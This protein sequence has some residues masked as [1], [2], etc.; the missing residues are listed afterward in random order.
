MFSRIPMQSLCFFIIKTSHCS[1]SLEAVQTCPLW[2]L[3]CDHGSLWIQTVLEQSSP[4]RIFQQERPQT[5]TSAALQN[6]RK[7]LKLPE[8]DG[9]GLPKLTPTLEEESVAFRR[10][11]ED[12][13]TR[14][15]KAIRELKPAPINIDPTKNFWTI[16]NQVADEHDNNL[17]KKYSGDLDTSLLFAT[18]FF[19]VD[20]TIIFQTL[21]SHTGGSSTPFNLVPFKVVRARSIFFASLAV[22]SFVAFIALLGKQWIL[23]Y[24]RV[25]T[26]GSIIDR[27]K[28]RQVKFVGLQKWGLHFIME[29]LPVLLQLALLL[30]NIGLIVYFWDL[31]R[32]AADVLLAVTCTGFAF[33]VGMAVLAT[34]W[35]DCP[36]QTPLSLVLLRLLPWVK[37]I[38]TRVQPRAW[39][40]R[41]YAALLQPKRVEG[42]GRQ[43][44][45]IGP[46]HRASIGEETTTFQLVGNVREKSIHNDAYMRLSNPVFWRTDPLFTPPLTLDTAAA[47]GFWLIENSTDFSAAAAVAAAFP[48]FQ[49][50]VHHHSIKALIRLRDTYTECFRAPK[51]DEPARL[52]ALQSAAAY[53]VL[54]HAWL[55]W[56]ESNS[57]EVEVEKPPSDL[58]LD[59]LLLHKDSD[60]WHGCDLFEYLLRAHDRSVPVK[61]AEFLSYIAPYW[62]CGDSDST[63]RFRSGHLQSLDELITVLEVSKALIPTTL[64][65]CVLCV[66]AAMDFPLHP[67]DLIRVD[68]SKYLV[69]TF[70]MAVEHIHYVVLNRGRRYRHAAEALEILLTLVGHTTLPLVDAAWIDELLKLAADGD[71][72]DEVFTLF[73]ELSARRDSVDPVQPLKQDPQ[74]L[75][76]T[77]TSETHT[78]DDTLFSKVVDNIQTRDWEDPAVSGGLLAIR[79]IRQLEPSLLNDD[80]LQTFYDAMNRDNPFRVRQAAYDVMVVTQNQW[81]ELERLRPKLEDLDF[82]RQMYHVVDDTNLSDYQRSFLTMMEVLSKEVYWHPYLRKAMDIWLPFRREGWSQI[83]NIIENVGGLPS[84]KRADHS[85]SSLDDSL[86]QLI[87][88]GWREA[89]GSL[90]PRGIFDTNFLK[91]LAE[92]TERFNLFDDGHREEVLT[93]VENVIYALGRREDYGFESPPKDVVAIVD[94]LQEKLRS[95]PKR[96]PTDD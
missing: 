14:L 55:L 88:D 43:M 92:V 70:K 49:W 7:V 21:P 30:L 50:P 1:A 28:E 38:K 90:V 52:Q 18:L 63:V 67:E 5:Q 11:E 2:C 15:E 69:S 57:G 61:S 95:P 51:V 40:R 76:R 65:N 91:P 45:P 23:H 79:N 25:S 16:Y 54:Y 22:T 89:S 47:A 85:S 73:L 35:K 78:P 48:E 82:F 74:S 72:A 9:T 60:E 59:L 26:W 4:R 6:K 3:R 53:Y 93:E 8:D 42:D 12:R 36:F 10:D 17:L 41:L 87:V 62:C 32:S 80:T 58:P 29:A 13:F 64:T 34:I 68:K 71:M 83:F 20:T 39:L 24:T 27:G 19:A 75:G 81:L 96:K 31:D 86:Q 33:Y 37:E 56:S 94:A 44:T 46:S 66:G 84:G 77:A